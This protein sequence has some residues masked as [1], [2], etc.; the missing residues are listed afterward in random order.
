MWP[1]AMISVYLCGI[2]VVFCFIVG[3][4]LGI[5]AAHNS[6]VSAIVRPINDT[7]QTIPLFV[8]LIPFVMLFKIGDF[9]GLLAIIIY[10]IVPSIRYA[11]N[12]WELSR[13]SN[14]HRPHFGL[15]GEINVPS[16]YIYISRMFI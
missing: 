13:A 3:T 16:I 2:A 15:P 4:S 9:T 8:I 12:A 10:A 11:E 14:D 5:W 1:E 7:L 6:V